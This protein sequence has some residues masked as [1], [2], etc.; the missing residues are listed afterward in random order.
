MVVTEP[1]QKPQIGS[2]RITI[3]V[4]VAKLGPCVKQGL[5]L[6]VSWI[7]QGKDWPSPLL[8]SLISDE[9]TIHEI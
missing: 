9:H 7:I 6:A 1:F 5:Q 2:E 8:R 4:Q 3:S